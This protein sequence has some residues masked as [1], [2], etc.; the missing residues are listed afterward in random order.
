MKKKKILLGVLLAT[1][2]FGMA[3]CTNTSKTDDDADK[4]TQTDQTKYTITF[5]SKGGS[6]VGSIEVQKDSKATAPTAPTKAADTTNT[7][8]FAGWYKDSACTQAFDFANETITGDIT[9]Y[10]KWTATPIVKYSVTFELNGGTGSIASQ[11]IV[12]GGKAT[13]PTTNPTKAADADN[14][15]AFAGWFKDAALST[16][17]NFTT[18]T[19]NSATTI[20]AKWTATPITK[21]TVSFN[22]N[23]GTG[24]IDSQQV[25]EGGKATRPTTDPTKA[26]DAENTYEFAGWFKDAGLTTEFDFATETINSATTIYA[27][28]TATPIPVTRYTVTFNLN[29]GTGSIADQQIIE[30][31]KVT[32]PAD[33][34]KTATAS[35]TYEFAG[36][37]KDAGLTTKFDFEN[38]TIT[39]A[40]TLYAKWIAT[41]ILEDNYIDF[42]IEYNNVNRVLEVG[43]TIDLT[44]LKV[45]GLDLSFNSVD[46]AASEYYVKVINPNGEVC[47]ITD[48]V[49]AGT[50][51]IEI[52][53][54]T[55]DAKSFAINVKAAQYKF[56]IPLT[57]DDYNES[58]G[59]DKITTGDMTFSAETKIYES[60]SLDITANTGV[61]LQVTDSN[62]NPVSKDYDGVTYNS[63]LQV[64]TGTKSLKITAKASGSITVLFATDATRTIDCTDGSSSWSSEAPTAENKESMHVFTIE[65]VAGKTYTFTSSTGGSNIYAIIFNGS[66]D[67]TSRVATDDLFINY[68]ETEFNNTTN[69]FNASNPNTLTVIS[70]DNYGINTPVA[71]SD[72]EIVVKNSAQET[73]TGE[74]E[75]A[76]TYTVSVSYGGKTESY[77]ISVIDLNTPISAISVNTTDATTKFYENGDAF[78]AEGI[79]VTATR[80]SV[81]STLRTDEYTILVDSFTTAGTYV[82][83]ITSVENPSVSTSYNV[84]Y[85]TIDSIVINAPATLNV[86]TGT[87]E[88]NN[89]ATAEGTYTDGEKV[90]LDITTKLYSDASY[91]T[92]VTAA[93]AFA[94]AGATVYA[95]LTCRDVTKTTVITVKDFTTNA[96]DFETATYTVD[97][98][99]NIAAGSN[100]LDESDVVVKNIGI[101]GTLLTDYSTATANDGSGRTFTK[102]IVTT[103]GMSDTKYYELTTTTNAIVTIYFTATDGKFAEKDQTKGGELVINDVQVD[104]VK[105]NK[106]NKIAYAYTFETDANTPV[107]IRVSSNRIALFGVVVES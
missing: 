49:I 23:G 24:S 70:Q 37:Y 30:G 67:E 65:A 5:D 44:G 99:G 21:Y 90:A 73:V 27:K 50:Y 19:I 29:G 11:Q 13:R 25:A 38:D 104:T 105:G 79:V 71:L 89:H 2:A 59:T 69:K 1:A 66:V 22:L 17:F 101:K 36:W 10:A 39:T 3:A 64:N 8:T 97:G 12:A 75:V 15:Y 103:G 86:N 41:P 33:P 46:L 53:V 81:E 56:S 100:L 83:T 78:T 47:D 88:Y 84:A 40:T 98:D 52:H 102:A 57:A 42:S 77:T 58:R 7:Y 93:T 94:T 20:Y 43:N 74:L 62:G 48:P 28:W 106:D 95:K 87:T 26:A 82:V 96:Y 61:K 92:E 16:E 45:S 80:G 14:T 72:C 51:T 85:N 35:E 54:G 63:R 107:K 34:T 18:E 9:L 4:Q 91:E 60:K 68:T 6:T 55:L 32:K 76:D 31:G